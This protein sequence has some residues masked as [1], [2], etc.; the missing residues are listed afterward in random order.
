MEDVGFL[1]SPPPLSPEPLYP[2]TEPQSWQAVCED[3]LTNYIEGTL[4]REFGRSWPF[5]V[6]TIR[7]GNATQLVVT[8]PRAKDWH[9]MPDSTII[10]TYMDST[11]ERLSRMFRFKMVIMAEIAKATSA[12][13]AMDLTTR[14]CMSRRR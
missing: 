13:N 4:Q 12:K 7:R 1:R 14:F 8:A 6:H 9:L 10:A 3:A 5:G 2:S 11:F